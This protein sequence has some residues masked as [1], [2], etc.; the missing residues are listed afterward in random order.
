MNNIA[1]ELSDTQLDAI[2]GGCY[3]E[4]PKCEEK[5]HCKP[6][7]DDYDRYESRK[8]CE[9]PYERW[10]EKCHDFFSRYED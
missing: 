10:Y 4:P 1:Q 6:K 9:K 5:P 7:H 8:H 2:S 3:R